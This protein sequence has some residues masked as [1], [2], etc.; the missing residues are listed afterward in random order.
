MVIRKVYIIRN[1][2]EDMPKNEKGTEKDEKSKEK[3]EKGEKGE[4]KWR[5]DPMS[6]VIFGLILIIF[7]AIF[8][9][10]KFLPNPDLWFGWV[11][12][13]AGVILLLDVVVRSLRP[14][15]KRPVFGKLVIAVI[16][17]IL[18]AGTILEIEES[19]PLIPIAIGVVML[20]YYLTKVTKHTP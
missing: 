1:F 7:G 15:W 2:K 4:G 12:A 9:G 10:R 3:G 16:L 14:E 5:R 11:L 18:G 17:I 20:I 19:W 13:S 6:G 8:L